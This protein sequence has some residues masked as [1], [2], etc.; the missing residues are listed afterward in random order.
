M[1]RSEL[2]QRNDSDLVA[3]VNATIGGN[4]LDTVIAALT[5][6]A[7]RHPDN[8][9]LRA[10]LAIALN[11]RDSHHATAGQLP[12]AQIDFEHALELDPDNVGALFNRARLLA[13]QRRWTDALRNFSRLVL[14]R[15]DD[16][17]IELDHVET[18]A[19]AALGTTVRSQLE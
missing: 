12:S 9:V 15:P 3:A 11:N 10:R 2:R 14:L 18:A 19:L 4:D 1:N 16:A 5:V 13:R 7:L 17:E 6:L 8:L